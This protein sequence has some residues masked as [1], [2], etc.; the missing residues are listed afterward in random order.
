MIR[1]ALSLKL[2]RYVELRDYQSDCDITT[3]EQIELDRIVDEL[4]PLAE[5]AESVYQGMKATGEPEQE[6]DSM[7]PAEMAQDDLHIGGGNYDQLGEDRRG[8]DS[9]AAQLF[10][11]RMKRVRDCLRENGFVEFAKHIEDF[12]QST[13]ANWSYNGPD[14]VEWTT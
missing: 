3:S 11:A 4:G 2:K 10:R 14:N 1:A 9:P 6:L 5:S 7:T 8:M 13:G 12:V